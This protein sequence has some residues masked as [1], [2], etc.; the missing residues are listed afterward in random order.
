MYLFAGNH[1]AD[2]GVDEEPRF[3]EVSLIHLRDEAKARDNLH[4]RKESEEVRERGRERG[5]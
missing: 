2:G 5:G 3:A 1:H 4:I